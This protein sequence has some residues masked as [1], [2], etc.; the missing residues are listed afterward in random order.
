M[1]FARTQISATAWTAK[2]REQGICSINLWESVGSERRAVEFMRIEAGDLVIL[3]K[4]QKI[5]ETSGEGRHLRHPFTSSRSLLARP[6]ANS[7]GMTLGPVGVAAQ[8]LDCVVDQWRR[9]DSLDWHW[10]RYR[11]NKPLCLD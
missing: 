11:T 7:C 5:G 8:Y 6:D 1:A 9:R 2:W 10:L 4:N 3:K